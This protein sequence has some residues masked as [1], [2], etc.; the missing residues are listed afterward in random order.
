MTHRQPT[1]PMATGGRYVLN[2]PQALTNRF[3]TAKPFALYADVSD[4][5][6]LLKR[7]R[8]GTDC[9]RTGP[10]QGTTIASVSIRMQRLV[11]NVS[12]RVTYIASEA[13]RLGRYTRKQSQQTLLVDVSVIEQCI[14]VMLSENPVDLL[15]WKLP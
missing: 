8:Q 15:H 14:S 12:S 11:I 2:R 1:L 4:Q 7:K 9:C 3:M 10:R 13:Y 5:Y 6:M